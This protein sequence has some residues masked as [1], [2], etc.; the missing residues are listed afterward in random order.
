MPHLDVKMSYGIS[1]KIRPDDLLRKLHDVLSEQETIKL[2]QI[3]S[4]MFISDFEYIGDVVETP[5]D[6]VHVEIK[7]MPGRSQEIKQTI[8][9]SL[10]EVVVKEIESANLKSNNT[11]EVSELDENSYSSSKDY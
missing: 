1:S 7:L 8:S 5:Q 6:Y 10:H 11:V 9:K 4:K 2:E 3:K